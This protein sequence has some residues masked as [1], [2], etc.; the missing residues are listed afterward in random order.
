MQTKA[1]APWVR[2]R[3]KAAPMPAVALV[4]LVF[5]TSFLAALFPRAVD[6]YESEGLRTVLREAGPDRSGIEVGLPTGEMYQSALVNDVNAETIAL[7]LPYILDELNEPLAVDRSEIAH[8]A[9]PN[10]PKSG[11]DPWLPRPEGVDPTF[12]ISTQDQVGKHSRVIEGRL[13]QGEGITDTSKQAEAAVTAET[14]KALKL[15]VGSVIHFAA[16]EGGEVGVKISGIVEPR[17]PQG[18][19]WSYD[20]ALRTPALALTPPTKEP[21][22]KYWHAGLLLAPEASG[23]LLALDP[24][25]YVYWRIPTDL[26]GITVGDLPGVGRQVAAIENG[27]ALT[28]LHESVGPAALVS[29]E[30]DTITGEFLTAREAITPVVSVAVYGIGAVALIVLLMTGTLSAARRSGEVALLRARGGSVRGIAVRL[31]AETAVV[32]VPAAALGCWLAALLRPD[33]RPAPA[34]IASAAVALIACTTLPVRAVAGHLRLRAHGGRE[35][36]VTAKPSRRRTVAELTLLVL[37]VGAVV[38]LRRRG[39]EEADDLVSA[40]PVMVALIAALVLVRLYPLP[41]RIAGRPLMRRRGAIGFLSLARAGRTSSTQAL[42]LLALLVALTTAA[43]GGSVI[44]GIADARDDAALKAVGADVRIN[45]EPSTGLPEALA[46]RLRAVD[47]ISEVSPVYLDGNLRMPDGGKDITLIGVDPESYARLSAQTGLGAFPAG[48][49]KAPG[50]GALP[51]FAS[52]KVAERL[53]SG[54]H[55][56]RTPGGKFTFKVTGVR[57]TT[58]ANFGV[59]FLLID[60]HALPDAYDSALFATGSGFDRT[61][62]RKAIGTTDAPI[63]Y[64]LRAD[65]RAS[66]SDSPLR[67][68]AETVYGFAVAAGA[69]Y[70]VLAVLLSLLQTAPERTALVA[71]LRTMGLGK[72]QARRLLVLEALPQ[73]LAT[74]VALV[75]AW[76]T[77]RQTSLTELRAG[78]S[79]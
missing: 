57:E 3:L 69:G 26:D 53:G 65:E 42:P 59:D 1:V 49:L 35:D 13:P 21:P 23:F 12:V 19:Y 71:R 17:N 24:N 5:V 64:E 36:L 33:G 40:A 66:L 44:A 6:T 68:G 30:L 16:I 50:S 8:G 54:E 31:F 67:S 52:E 77:A 70:A 47:G 10:R 63:H 76:W 14:A 55:T 56:L 51:A 4:L 28:R 79:R 20:T 72:G 75:Q 11:L 27:P 38:A 22:S 45:A 7:T 34:L 15:K 18:S 9:K 60:S 46:G 39:S 58:P 78:D 29:T 32:A 37:A 62:I 48:E 41:I 73:V 2:T 43:F 74:G 61:D 25:P